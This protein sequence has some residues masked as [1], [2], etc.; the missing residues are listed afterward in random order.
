MLA[1]HCLALAVAI[2]HTV[3]L[4]YIRNKTGY[5]NMVAKIEAS[6]IN[7]AR[8][9]AINRYIE[10]SFSEVVKDL[11]TGA[12]GALSVGVDGVLRSFAGNLEVIDYRQLDPEQFRWFGKQQLS[13]W[14][15]DA[16][17]PDSVLSLVR[18]TIDGRLVT[19]EEIILHPSEKPQIGKK[20]S[21]TQSGKR[22][23]GDLSIRQSAACA[24]TYCESL[25]VCTPRGC[26]ACYFPNGPPNGRC[27]G[28]NPNLPPR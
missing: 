12:T 19:N 9:P 17:T 24:G 5:S 26:N 1:E 7:R 28:S 10:G 23:A 3:R 6:A 8:S 20:S 22:D 16:K 14:S 27:L 25:N 15:D 11:K 18:D 13:A 2:L 4:D 21:S